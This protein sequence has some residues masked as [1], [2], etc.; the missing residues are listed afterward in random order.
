MDEVVRPPYSESMSAELGV[1][2]EVV[3][4]ETSDSLCGFET[5]AEA[6]QA[7]AAMA[8]DD[9]PRARYLA[10]IAFD[11]DGEAITLEAAADL[12]HA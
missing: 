6:K 3:D 10:L 1:S 11:A 9:P 4:L 5:L 8:D 7:L 12:T 2:F